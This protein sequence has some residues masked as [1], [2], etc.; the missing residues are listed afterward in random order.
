M[1]A[2]EKTKSETMV[3][4]SFCRK[5]IEPGTGIMFV[6]NDGRVFNFCAA[7][8]EKH[9]IVLNHKPRETKWSDAYIKGEQEKTAEETQTAKPVAVEA[10]KQ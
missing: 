6:K 2:E 3:K 4:C 8:C 1:Q 9:L 7:K 10:K 5:N